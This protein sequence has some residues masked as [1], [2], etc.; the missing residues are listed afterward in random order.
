MLEFENLQG[1]AKKSAKV[2]YMKLKDGTNEFRIVG[3]ILPG[4]SYWVK[5]ANGKDISFECLQFDRSTE[6]FNSS[7]PDPIKEANLE[8]GKGNPLRCSWSYRCQVINRATGELEVL[9]LK[10]GML[11]DIIKYAKKKKLNPTS[12]DNGVW[13]KVER[14]F[15]GPKAFNVKYTVDPFEFEASALTD[16]ELALVKDLK[17]I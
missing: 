2:K 13:L 4:Y 6:A 16:E 17:P 12:F 15:E 14:I 9:T 8:D 10:K 1:E 3:G 5:G 7:L 11:Q